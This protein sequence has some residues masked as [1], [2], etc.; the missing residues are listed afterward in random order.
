MNENVSMFI[1]T[2]LP[3]RHPDVRRSNEVAMI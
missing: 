2:F 1:R 3:Q